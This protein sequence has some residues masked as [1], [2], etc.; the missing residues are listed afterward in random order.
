MI[1]G[2]CSLCGAKKV[3]KVT[4]PLNKKAK[5]PNPSKHLTKK[6][7]VKSKKNKTRKNKHSVCIK[8]KFSVFTA[9]EEKEIK[10]NKTAKKIISENFKL[11]EF[12]KNLLTDIFVDI[13]LHNLKY[14]KKDNTV[15]FN[16]KLEEL[17][18]T[19]LP[20]FIENSADAIGRKVS[21][22]ENNVRLLWTGIFFDIMESE[23]F[24][25]GNSHISKVDENGEPSD[26]YI[27]IPKVKL[28][29]PS[30]ERTLAKNRGFSFC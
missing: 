12:Y 30:K 21:Q 10:D 6:T 19:S 4:C 15:K 26:K 28:V 7:S 8:I 9:D 3:N 1:G 18:D 13:P 16:V 14:D 5:N 29:F 25:G 2:D 24:M 17:K 20:Y 11:K 23:N 22:L 27:I